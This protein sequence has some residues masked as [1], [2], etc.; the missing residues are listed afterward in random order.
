MQEIRFKEWNSIDRCQLLSV[1]YP[2]QDYTEILEKQ[3]IS[4]KLHDFTANSQRKFL[5]DRKLSLESK[6]FI[7]LLDLSENCS[8]SIQDEVDLV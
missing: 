7:V 8:S 1:T 3:L 4:Q 5:K 2:M 6:E